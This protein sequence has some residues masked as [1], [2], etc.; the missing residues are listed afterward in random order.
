MKNK[1]LFGFL[2]IIFLVGCGKEEETLFK[3]IDVVESLYF[4]NVTI[5]PFATKTISIKYA[6][7][8]KGDSVVDFSEVINFEITEILINNNNNYSLHKLND[9]GLVILQRDNE[10]VDLTNNFNQTILVSGKAD[11]KGSESMIIQRG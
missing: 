11:V 8:D 5:E 10:H 3:P 7:M 2:F 1:I 6:L 4:K 9:S